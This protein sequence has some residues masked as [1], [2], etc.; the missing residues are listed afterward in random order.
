MKSPLHRQYL[1]EHLLE[2]A[3]DE[4]FFEKN[5]ALFSRRAMLAKCFNGMGALGLAAAVGPRALGG[6]VA[7]AGP[8]MPK[9]PH[10]PARAKR[11]IHLWMNGAPSQVDT[12]DPKP[13]LEKYA[14]KRPE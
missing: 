3:S 1:W 5:A 10:F 2:Q 9:Q 12:F 11:V 7:Q 8:L 6:E 4:R 13:A 14:G